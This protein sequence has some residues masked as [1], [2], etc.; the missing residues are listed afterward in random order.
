MIQECETQLVIAHKDRFYAECQRMIEERRME[1][2]AR[3]YSLL[4][5]TARGLEPMLDSF[6]ETI[7]TVGERAVQ[8]L[9]D[10]AAKV[11]AVLVADCRP[12]PVAARSWWAPVSLVRSVRLHD[13]GAPV[14]R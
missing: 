3:T 4:S 14:C 13:A 6:R 5:R 9:G 12:S 7:V 10:S 2:L 8:L 11:R 1:D